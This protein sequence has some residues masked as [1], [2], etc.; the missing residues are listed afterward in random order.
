[1]RRTIIAVFSLACAL[2]QPLCADEF[3][4]LDR[5]KQEIGKDQL[6]SSEDYPDADGV[7]LYDGSQVEMKLDQQYRLYTVST[8]HSIKRLFRN[9]EKYT[10]VD[11]KIFNGQE[12]S[13]I[14]ARTIR[15]DGSILKLKKKDVYLI[16]GEGDDATLY[17]DTKTYRFTFAG[18]DKNAIVE[19][20]Y[21]VR[22]DY[23][24][25]RDTWI[26]QDDLPTV[27]NTY[28]LTLPQ[29]LLTDVDFKWSWNYRSYNYPDFP[30][31]VKD[32][33]DILET[34]HYKAK[35][36]YTWSL[37]DIPAFEPDPGMPPQ[38]L[39][40]AMVKFSPGDWK[41]WNDIA[42]WFSGGLKEQLQEGTAA[43]RVAAD[44][45]KEIG[46][47]WER[48]AAL[49]RYVQRMRYI[50][51][52]LGDGG[53][54]PAGPDKVLERKYGDCKDKATLL[55][56]MLRS[57]GVKAE[58][59]LVLTANAGA[60]DP[61]FPNLG[62]NH[63]IAKATLSD[64]SVLWLDPTVRYCQA[65]DLP[66]AD[67]A[68]NVL[69]IHDDNT[70]TIERTPGTNSGA[71][72]S[73]IKLTADL[74]NPDTARFAVRITYRGEDAIDARYSLAEK[75]DKEI[76]EHCKAMISGTFANAEITR[77]QLSNIDSLGRDPELAFEFT[78]RDA[79]QP[80][81]DLLLLTFD[82]F[83]IFG[84]LE[85]LSKKTRRYPIAFE[86]P[87]QLDKS[88]VITYPAGRYEVRNAPKALALSGPQLAYTFAD[89]AAT[90]GTLAFRELFRVAST[91]IPAEQ[92]DQVLQFY[93]AMQKQKSEKII[94]THA[95]AA[96]PAPAGQP[97]RKHR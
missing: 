53:Y 66:A 12:L 80:Q 49:F 39:F 77:Y 64:C 70:G 8:G 14:E 30:A 63:M 79:L 29:F 91:R 35:L 37:S 73:D 58:A 41:T 51:L 36:R 2:A 82:P 62:F 74:A 40:W 6:P 96:R 65:G 84:N 43:A 93:D 38:S 22:N 5:I 27:R 18:V 92:Y 54:R 10:I 16:K 72:G 23:P 78:V 89:S 76:A 21:T 31:P 47:P 60:I 52:D 26:I 59:V 57:V 68:I 61:G 75:T 50:S 45:T 44:L 24:F 3:W 48:T 88:V 87:R 81:G 20:W 17:S 97:E 71:N 32:N 94:F 34:E 19:Y 69:V 11:L 13:S 90:P 83:R 42:K 86:C 25:R 67:Q 7:V 55:I 46:D 4:S 9:I 28:Q 85:W 95:T 33:P 56:A 1:M 15:P